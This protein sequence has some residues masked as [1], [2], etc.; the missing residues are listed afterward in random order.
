M[1]A[2]QVVT[3]FNED[4]ATH[5]VV[6]ANGLCSLTLTPGQG[7][8][9]GG[10]C[11]SRFTSLVGSYPYTEDGTFAGT[12]VTAPWPRSVT[13]TARTH[14]IRSGTGLPL[15]GRVQQ[16]YTGA[17]PPPPVR[18]LARRNSKQPFEP[19][20]T[21]RT[22]GAHQAIYR[23]KLNVRPAMTTTYIVEVTAQR[24]CYFPASRCAQPS[25]PFWTDPK[26]RPFTVR[27]RH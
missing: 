10:F 5:T 11:E 19:V 8:Y 27:I 22:R 23:W 14:T 2:G 6:F 12:V 26:S 13:L 25:G 15:Q 4:S 7:G 9:N 20:A 21:V 24:T 3:F 16:S 17:A 1:H 18:V